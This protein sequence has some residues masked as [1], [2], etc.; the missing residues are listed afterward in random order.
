MNRHGMLAWLFLLALWCGT[1]GVAQAGDWNGWLRFL[2]Y[3]WGDGYHGR[4]RG[5]ATWMHSPA[6]RPNPVP[7]S[8]APPLPAPPAIPR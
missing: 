5:H 6:P 3:G 2:G 1:G 8:V 4:S 7:E